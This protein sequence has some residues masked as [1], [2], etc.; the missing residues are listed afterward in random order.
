MIRPTRTHIAAGSVLGLADFAA[1]VPNPPPRPAAKP[2]PAADVIDGVS[3][4][5]LT[6]HADERGFLTELLTTRDGPIEP[7]VH[8]Y[9]VGA[10][11]GSIRAWVYHRFQFDRLGFA[12]GRFEVVL[13]D[14]RPG[15]PTANMLNVFMLGAVQPCLLRIPPLVVH[16][17]RNAGREPGY[18][19]NMPTKAYDWNAPD[20]CRIPWDDPRIPYT[21][22][23]R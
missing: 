16:G 8:V 21:F 20:K 3:A 13:Y 22:D 15:S 14:I 2:P 7:I 5:A 11:P 17:V 6:P 23:A 9:Q 1:D 4:T 19:I 18:F 10:L 12:N